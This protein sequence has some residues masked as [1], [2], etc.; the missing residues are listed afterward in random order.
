MPPGKYCTSCR[1]LGASKTRVTGGSVVA[2]VL[3]AVAAAAAAPLGAGAFGL[4]GLILMKHDKC[5]ACGGIMIPGNSPRALHELA[6][7]QQIQGWGGGQQ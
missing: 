1:R 3:A 2:W 4:L 6:Q 7:M 5:G